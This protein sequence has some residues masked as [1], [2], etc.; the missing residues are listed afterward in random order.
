[1]VDLDRDFILSGTKHA[2]LTTWGGKYNPVIPSIVK[3]GESIKLST[4]S[5]SAEINSFDEIV[6]T[7]LVKFLFLPVWLVYKFYDSDLK[8]VGQ[9]YVKEIISKWIKL[10]LAWMEDSVTGSYLRPTYALF[11]LFGY[12]LCE[13]SN[14][15]F[16]T[17]TH[18]ITEEDIMF[19][20]MSGQHEIF[21]RESIKFPRISEL[22]FKP[23]IDGTNVISEGDFRNPKLYTQGAIDELNEIESAI[24]EN[25]ASS[26]PKALTPELENFR[27]FTIA[28]KVNDTG[29]L[30]K[31]WVFHVPDLC[32]PLPRENGYPKSIAIEVELTNKKV[33]Y[34][35]SLSRYRD[36]NKYG[37]VYWLVSSNAISQSLRNAYKEIGGTG[38]C[39]MKVLECIIPFPKI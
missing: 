2:H 31:D 39:K 7:I 27:Y 14:I 5:T 26:N 35:E 28:K 36:N 34:T 10:G 22:G 3:T 23:S 37:T 8:I 6:L 33:M 4:A 24:N 15:P 16:N 20:I 18:T 38:S 1:M 17:L 21:K 32:I 9:N 25:L 12:D 30:R 13:Y 29:I 19:Q 11:E